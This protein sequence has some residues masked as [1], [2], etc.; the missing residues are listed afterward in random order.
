MEEVNNTATI[1]CRLSSEKQNDYK[2]IPLEVQEKRC[3]TYCDN[4]NIEVNDV[5]YDI[6]SGRNMTKRNVYKILLDNYGNN[7][8]IVN[9]V[10]RFS[11]NICQG[12]DLLNELEKK[13]INF[14]SVGDNC[15]Y[16][17]EYDKYQIRNLLNLS[18]FE[19]DKISSRIKRSL[20]VRKKMGE[21][22]GK[23]PYGYKI[24]RDVDGIRKIIPNKFEFNIL[25][26][27]KTLYKK[28]YSP[29]DISNYLNDNEIK[30][31][32]KEWKSTSIRY[33]LKRMKD[34]KFDK[35]IKEFNDNEID[36]KDN[37]K[38]VND[39]KVKKNNEYDE[40]IDDNVIIEFENDDIEKEINKI[41][42]FKI[43][44]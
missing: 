43:N 5:I 36:I 34:N 3:Q 33:L 42:K 18:Q 41:E 31:N 22:I 16:R 44:K 28:K 24:I 29:S 25:R 20:E 40:E 2:D 15:G 26:I 23:T 4:N 27:I 32:G 8:V 6:G 30:R 21:Y 11:R 1:Y 10:S 19:S 14:I 37:D 12:I 39:K 9:D 35:S 38:K 13:N 7:N 17:T